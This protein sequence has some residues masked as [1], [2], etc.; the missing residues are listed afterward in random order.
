[1]S[2]KDKFAE[3]F[4]DV[5][6]ENDSKISENVTD[7]ELDIILE[8][9]EVEDLNESFS[10]LVEEETFEDKVEQVKVALKTGFIGSFKD[11]PNP[12]E[13][14][15]GAEYR[16]LKEGIVYKKNAQGLWESYIKDGKD[17][18]TPRTWPT[19]GGVGDKDV[20]KMIANGSISEITI[21]S[22]AS[23]INPANSIVEAVANTNSYLQIELQNQSS[24][25][26]ASTDFVATSD[27]GSDNTYYID[28]GINGSQYNQSA[29]WQ[30]NG[31]NDG[32]LYTVGGDLSIGTQSSGTY[33]NFFV[34]GTSAQNIIMSATSTG[35]VTTV[36]TTLYNILGATSSTGSTVTIT[37][38]S[39]ANIVFTAGSLSAIL[40]ATPITNEEHTLVSRG[41][42]LIIN[43]NGKQI[44]YGSASP[45]NSVTIA[46]TVPYVT[47]I[48]DGTYW[49]IK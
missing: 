12:N 39:P 15:D 2:L 37:T 7:T 14:G 23:S 17:G 29:T 18:Q 46:N 5:I 21:L 3:Y 25:S 45:Q 47:A 34:A 1:M 13:Y 27:V 6:K 4:G 22:G 42:G 44:Y 43:G 8:G 19:G 11:V 40:P 20:I 35:I 30:I 36:P 31:P 10:K 26:A 24:G 9:F 48:W 28:L 33:L 41:N 38:G 49:C 16:N 32:Y